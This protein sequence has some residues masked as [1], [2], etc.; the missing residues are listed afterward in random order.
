MP[1]IAGR[2]SAAV[3]AG[4]S[5]VVAA[6]YA[7]PFGAFDSLASVTVPT[8]GVSSIY[9]GGI[10]TGY[11]HL[12]IRG[13]GR[14]TYA[15]SGLSMTMNLNDI[16]NASTGYRHHIYASGSG[17]V[18]AYAASYYGTIGGTPGANVT[19]NI[20]GGIAM[21]ILDYANTSKTK[22]LRYFN[23]YDAN[24]SGEVI[25]GSSYTP[26]TAAITSI[27]LIID[28]TWAAGSKL[29]LYGVK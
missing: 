10:P 1:I 15:G 23:G 24:G 5:R 19:A 8:G 20:F 27:E 7:G 16:T 2:A 29:A 4:F 17:S 11:K 18:S 22:T 13:A 25:F 14:G 28:G 3:G 9:F 12:E 6:A 26:V 21:S